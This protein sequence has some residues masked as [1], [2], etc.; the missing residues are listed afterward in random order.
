MKQGDLACKLLEQVVDFEDL[1]S[2][3]LQIVY[4]TIL[5]WGGDNASSDFAELLQHSMDL[6]L[7]CV[8]WK[9][10]LLLR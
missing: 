10:D 6:V 7:P 1:I 2:K 5:H 3:L 4:S 8:V 9:P